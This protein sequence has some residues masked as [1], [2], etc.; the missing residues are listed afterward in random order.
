MTEEEIRVLNS[1][2]NFKHYGKFYEKY[3]LQAN[4]A[5]AGGGTGAEG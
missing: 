4:A 2:F 5:G 1:D 3:D